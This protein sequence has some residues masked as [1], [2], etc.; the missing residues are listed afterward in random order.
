M[1]PL[2]T[3]L[4]R[5]VGLVS[6]PRRPEAE[7]ESATAAAAAAGGGA[8]AAGAAASD[9]GVRN[10]GDD[11]KEK[12]QW[13]REQRERDLRWQQAQGPDALLSPAEFDALQV[14]PV[15]VAERGSQTDWGLRDFS[16]QTPV[17]LM[18]RFDA[19]EAEEAEMLSV[20][21]QHGGGRNIFL[22]NK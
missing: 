19:S 4:R 20:L 3:A 18:H 17:W 7:P 10:A 6:E 13:E 11:A 2:V 5:A 9:A 21:K 8:G 1:Q 22:V 15:R 16:V 12:E 14:M